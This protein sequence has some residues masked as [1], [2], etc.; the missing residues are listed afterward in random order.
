MGALLKV[1]AAAVTGSALGL[2][3]KKNNPETSLLLVAAVSMLAMYMSVDVLTAV[4]GFLREVA[5]ETG[6]PNATLGIVLKTAG[7][8]VVT[9][10]V[11]DICRDAGQ[12]SAASGVEFFGAVS[13]IYLALPLFR[14]VLEML[15]ALL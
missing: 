1:L 10:L 14:T 2:V 13:S 9:K 6:I 8:S 4:L 11:A 5:A 7:V 3:I 12:T 15:N